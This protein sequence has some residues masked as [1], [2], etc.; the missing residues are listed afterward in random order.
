MEAKE[1]G[2]GG[3]LY[4]PVNNTAYIRHLGLMKGTYFCRVVC[5][6]GDESVLRAR[7]VCTK[8]G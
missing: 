1:R 6:S 2:N 7:R 4:M 8:H 5:H 3:H